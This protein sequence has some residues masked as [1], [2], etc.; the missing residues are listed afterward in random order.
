MLYPATPGGAD[1]RSL[2]SVLDPWIKAGIEVDGL[3]STTPDLDDVSFP[4]GA[5]KCGR[6]RAPRHRKGNCPM[7]AIA[8]T[9]RRLG[10][11]LRRQLGTCWA[12][13]P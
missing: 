13:H 2:R 11:E 10:H 8:Y 12:T 5:T 9:V 3:T 6:N 4:Y 7:N 1:V